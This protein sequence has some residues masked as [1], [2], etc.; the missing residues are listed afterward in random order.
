MLVGLC[1]QLVNLG[2]CLFVNECI[3]KS[4]TFWHFGHDLFTDDA[5][6]QVKIIVDYE[7]VVCLLQLELLKVHIVRL[8]SFREEVCA[9]RGRAEF[10]EQLKRVGNVSK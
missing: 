3:R 4:N 6:E 5:S 8:R 7:I 2:N 10:L 9:H 1:S